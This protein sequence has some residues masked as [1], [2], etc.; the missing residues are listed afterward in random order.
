LWDLTARIRL[1]EQLE[2]IRRTMFPDH[3]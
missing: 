3:D 2:P 1:N